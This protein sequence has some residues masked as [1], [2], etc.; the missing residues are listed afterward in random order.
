MVIKSYIELYRELT[1]KQIRAWNMSRL[2]QEAEM[3]LSG[4]LPP[5]V[6][7]ALE[8][9]SCYFDNLNGGKDCLRGVIT[10]LDEQEIWIT[11]ADGSR[12]CTEYSDIE[13][14]W[15]PPWKLENKVGN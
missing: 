5:P 9:I 2:D 11:F 3:E 10:S 7:T 1:G 8:K 4:S 13:I 12:F 14:V 15:C 6:M